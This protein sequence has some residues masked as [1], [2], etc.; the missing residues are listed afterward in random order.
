M[1]ENMLTV[2]CGKKWF[3]SKNDHGIYSE[4]INNKDI[5]HLGHYKHIRK[6][7]NYSG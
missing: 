3:W 2:L 5:N 1:H 4:I 6:H 7:L